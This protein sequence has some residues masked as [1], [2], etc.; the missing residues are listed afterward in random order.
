M[1]LVQPLTA[2]MTALIQTTAA[3]AAAATNV[4]Q[5]YA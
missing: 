5:E 2:P 3:A 1:A 4:W